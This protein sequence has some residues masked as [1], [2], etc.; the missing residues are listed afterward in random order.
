MFIAHTRETDDAE[1]PLIDHLLETAK[2]AKGHAAPWGG[3]ESAELC[4]LAHDI[5]KYSNAF[6]TRIRGGTNRVDHATAGG[7]FLY[8]EYGKSTLGILMA[9]CVMGHHGGIPNGGSN[10][11]ASGDDST[12][13]SRLKRNVT[14]YSKYRE[15]L[16]LPCLE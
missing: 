8:N 15:D 4:G 5:G 2:R 14:D 9:Y 6:Q 1:Q 11:Q 13:F 10:V 3:S 12:L 16:A 7:Q